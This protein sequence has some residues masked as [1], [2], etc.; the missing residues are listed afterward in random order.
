MKI[1]I[2]HASAGYGHQKVA[3]VIAK[4][5]RDR[6]LADEEVKVFDALAL[7][8]PF[9]GRLYAA[10]YYYS[11]KYLPGVWGWF[12]ETFDRAP[13]AS[14]IQPLRA[15][16]NAFFGRALLRLAVRENPDVII[17]THFLPAE[18]FSRAKRKGK[19]K[20]TILTV[21]TDYHPHSFWINEGTDDYWVMGEEGAL[22]LRQKGVAR[23]K[24]ITG[25]IPID[26]RFKPLGRKIEG[27]RQYGFSEKR[28]TILLTSGSFGLGPHG[29]IL[30][31]LGSFAD[32]IQCFVVCGNNH[33]LK[34]ELEKMSLP[35]PVRIFGFVDFMA[36]LM[37]AS[38]LLI[39]KPGGSTTTESLAKGIPMVVMNPIPGQETHNAQILKDRHASFF[40]ESPEQI[41]LIVKNIFE[42]PDMMKEKQRAIE[43]LAKPNAAD[44]LVSFVLKAKR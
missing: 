28:F 18:L 27:L 8:P 17:S 9:F 25:G 41:Q 33:P 15:V 39:A 7:T 34:T 40:M 1:F 12:Y 38:D 44:D 5:F 26:G 2:F 30:T 21:V 24:I 31:S 10:I 35:F 20:A 23:E 13:F 19:I 14:W 3:E 43:G 42:H 32:R 16:N 4:T 22:G 29:A 6:G 11:V 36:D 37:E